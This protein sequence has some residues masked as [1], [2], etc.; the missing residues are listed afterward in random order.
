MNMRN[1]PE[2][3]ENPGFLTKMRKQKLLHDMRA[4]AE[5]CG[6]LSDEEIETEIQTARSD[7]KARRAASE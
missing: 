6:F 7:I 3:S 2:L 1:P 4:E 5:S